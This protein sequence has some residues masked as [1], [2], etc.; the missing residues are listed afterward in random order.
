MDISLPPLGLQEREKQRAAL[1]EKQT[2]KLQAE[3]AHAQSQAHREDKAVAQAA[4]VAAPRAAR[5]W[6]CTMVSRSRPQA[7]HSRIGIKSQA[8]HLHMPHVQAV[9]FIDSRVSTGAP[10]PPRE[11][12]T[13]AAA[14]SSS[15]V[16]HMEQ[17]KPRRPQSPHADGL[18]KPKSKLQV[19]NASRKVEQG[20]SL[21]E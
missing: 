19:C 15:S 5:V 7:R 4:A 12:V 1:L 17:V 16:D 3:L 14:P 8:R 2:Q 10:V 18:E 21:H 9:M 20:G 13:Q 11:P 6:M